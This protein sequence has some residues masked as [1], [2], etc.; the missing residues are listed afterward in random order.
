MMAEEDRE[1]LARAARINKELAATA[2][3]L[4]DGTLDEDHAG[5]IGAELV[6]VGRAYL[7]RGRTIPG[8]TMPMVVDG[9]AHDTRRPAGEPS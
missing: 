1:F 4:A 2:L 3:P 9:T 8:E 7:G 5:R 6:A